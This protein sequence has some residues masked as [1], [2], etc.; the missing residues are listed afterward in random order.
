MARLKQKS[1]SV[2]DLSDCGWIQSQIP[3]SFGSGGVANLEPGIDGHLW[4][5]IPISDHA[6][7]TAARGAGLKWSLDEVFNNPN[8]ANWKLHALFYKFSRGFFRSFAWVACVKLMNSQHEITL[9]FVGSANLK[10]F[11]IDL[12][13]M[14]DVGYPVFES[15]PDVIE[16]I[17]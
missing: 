4:V 1:P 3:N 15:I 11:A 2:V 6:A 12:R 10:Q 9:G 17:P 5:M 14:I 13:Q 7:R 8:P 16:S